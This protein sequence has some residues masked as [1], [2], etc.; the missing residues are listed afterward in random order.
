[1]SK[2]ENPLFIGITDA[3]GVRRSVLECSKGILESLKRYENFKN[4]R[5]QKAVLILQFKGQ[6][7]DVAKG[8]SS[9]KSFL[10]Q[11]KEPESRPRHRREGTLPAQPKTEIERLERELNDIENKLNSLS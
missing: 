8:I 2:K 4:L 3:N 6:I 5:N 1:M 7:K 11:V 10:P 9:L